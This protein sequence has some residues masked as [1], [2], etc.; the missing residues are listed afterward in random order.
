MRV[1]HPAFC[2]PDATLATNLFTEIP[3]AA[4]RPVSSLIALLLLLCAISIADPIVIYHW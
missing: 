4:V 3:A 1:S 2:I